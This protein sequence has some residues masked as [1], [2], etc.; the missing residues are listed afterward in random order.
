MAQALLGGFGGSSLPPEWH[1]G[2][3][4]ALSHTQWR[5]RPDGYL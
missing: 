5:E 1:E 2:P 4:E 3:P